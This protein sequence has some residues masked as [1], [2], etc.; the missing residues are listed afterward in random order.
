MIDVYWLEQTSADVPVHHNWL[1][2]RESLLLNKIQFHKR[3]TD[4]QLGRWTAKNAVA[5]YLWR[6]GEG[7]SLTEIEIV[8][9]PC[10]APQVFCAN[11]PAEIAISLSHREKMAVCAVSP[12]AFALGCDLEMIEPHSNAFICDYFTAE[13]RSS[14]LRTPANTDLLSGLFWSAKESALKALRTGLRMDTRSVVVDLDKASLA[15]GS[16][17]ALRVRHVGGKVFSGW[18]KQ[19]GGMVRTIVADAPLRPPIILGFWPEVEEPHAISAPRSAALPS[20]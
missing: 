15:A 8:S 19:D 10:G 2:P 1:S 16:W 4:W 20:A 11:H 9:A 5:T 3:R 7:L 14:I 13:E 6:L 12:S 17:H 18:W